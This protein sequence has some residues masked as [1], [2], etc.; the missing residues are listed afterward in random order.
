MESYFNRVPAFPRDVPTIDL[1]C[2][3][4]TKL[5][6]GIDSESE[7]LFQ[8]CKE[9][10]FFLLDLKGSD[11]GDKMLEHAAFAFKLNEELMKAGKGELERYAY[12]PPE[13]LFG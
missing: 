8:S 6:A 7:Q 13:N 4:Y 9:N 12:K 3:S 2:L 1:R 11:E 10:G 5:I